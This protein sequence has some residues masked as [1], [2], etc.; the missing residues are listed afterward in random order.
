M[1]LALTTRLI[2]WLSIRE[3]NGLTT[4]RRD[5]YNYW[6]HRVTREEITVCLDSLIF[7]TLVE[8]VVS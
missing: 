7:Q 4:T 1:K 8:D 2:F 3:Q 6:S 5:I